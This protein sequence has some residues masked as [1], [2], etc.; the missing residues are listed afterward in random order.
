MEDFGKRRTAKRMPNMQSDSGIGNKKSQENQKS[1]AR[2]SAPQQNKTN[3]YGGKA[4]A[5][6]GQQ[7]RKGMTEQS[8]LYKAGARVETQRN[9]ARTHGSPRRKPSQPTEQKISVACVVR[10]VLLCIGSAVLF[11]L[12]S[13]YTLLFSVAHGP[14]KTVRNTLVLSAMQASA[15]KWVP[16]LFLSGDTV[17]QILDESKVIIVDEVDINDYNPVTPDGQKDEWE[18]AIDGMRLIYDNGSTFK[19]YVLLVKDPSRVFVGPSFEY[20]SSGYG[21]RIFDAA[22]MEGA[23][24]AINA[25]EYPD[26]GFSTGSVPLGIT[27]SKGKLVWADGYTDRT[28]MGMDNNNKLIVHEGM[29]KALATELGIRDGVSFKTGNILIDNDGGTVNF[30][31][32]DGDN[33]VAQRTAIGQR[34]DGT[35]IMIVTDGR[36]ASSLG[37]TRN[38]IIDMMKKYGAV[39]AGMLDGGSSSM[40]YYKNYYE[41]YAI[42]QANLDSWQ[43]MGLV[44]KYKAF[45]NPR[46]MPTF[47]LVKE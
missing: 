19:A 21:K 47:F 27:Y 18:D 34:A 15:T 22:S 7:L 14:S 10:R 3:C 31:Y 13:V 9:P 4:D 24:A 8:A 46:Y 43:M 29:N 11:L 39:T 28:F 37:A 35:I 33:G 41:K 17:Q 38:D 30:H 32:A 36:S 42:D 2:T 20:S 23:I 44:N 1:E 5:N 25:G 45:T 16:G 6:Y 26:N 40:M 12:L